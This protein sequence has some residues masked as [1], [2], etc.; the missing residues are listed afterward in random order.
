MQFLSHDKLRELAMTRALPPLLTPTEASSGPLLCSVCYELKP[1]A[2]VMHQ[3]CLNIFCAKDILEQLEITK[4]C[5]ICRKPLAKNLRDPSNP[6][7][8][9]KPIPIVADFIERVD[10]KCD[11][12]HE[13]MKY[14]SATVHHR[15]CPGEA[16]RHQIPA[17][18]PQRG[19]APL[20]RREV[21]SNAIEP[22]D[23]TEESVS[24]RMCVMHY[25][26]LQVGTRFANKNWKAHK[27][28]EMIAFI[29]VDSPDNFKLY[30]FSHREI[31]DHEIVQNFTHHRGATY[32][33]AFSEFPLLVS[34][35]ATLHLEDTGPPAYVPPAP[36]TPPPNPAD[37]D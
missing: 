18:L 10:Y 11:S 28:K 16:N 29:A 4:M 22:R 35:S 36:P 15:T 13:Q 19:V 3:D 24:R 8:I 34:H 9:C 7:F 32:I 21:I 2:M 6:T 26:G 17:H 20:V 30:K 1:F 14:H 33:T 37:L 27:I 25:N 12:C 5:P 31:Q 23:P